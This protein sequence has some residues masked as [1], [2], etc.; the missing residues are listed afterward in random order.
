[1]HRGAELALLSDAL[2]QLIDPAADVD[3][4][5]IRD[6]HVAVRRDIRQQIP[7]ARL[8]LRD[9]GEVDLPPVPEGPVLQFH[10]LGDEIVAFVVREGQVYARRLVDTMTDVESFAAE[11]HAECSRV[12]RMPVPDRGPHH[13]SLDALGALLLL[14]LDDLLADLE[15]LPLVV[16][17]PARLQAVPFEAL[18]LR[19]RPLSSLFSLRFAAGM[20]DLSALCLDEGTDVDHGTS[21]LALMVSDE[22]TPRIADETRALAAIHPDATV[23]TGADATVEALGRRARHHDVVHVACHG[24]YWPEHPS[25]SG[26][27]L[28]DRWVTAGEILRMDL[29]GCLVILNACA[30][31]RAY[32]TTSESVGL[33]W[34]LLAAGARGV[35]ATTWP[36]DD[37]VALAFATSFHQHLRAGLPAPEAV[38]EAGVDVSERFSDHPW[39]W[40]AH[41]YVA[42]GSTVLAQS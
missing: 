3:L 34:A 4:A 2:D 36:V 25:S 22:Q 11:W 42:S 20:H 1:M 7:H 26:L 15:G 23:L 33:T 8:P 38:R 16:V 35:V 37:S 30:T 6:T 10:V 13:H 14:P 32:D 40:A 21:V 27:R 24:L 31:G 18:P 41:R 5:A 19:G 39:A 12:Q 28:G 9:D 29:R 17:A